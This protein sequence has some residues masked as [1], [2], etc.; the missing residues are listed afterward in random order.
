MICNAANA[1][2]E[3]FEH[4]QATLSDDKLE[5]L[6]NL[7]TCAES[8]AGNLAKTLEALALFFA[9]SDKSSLPDK[10]TVASILWGLANQ[11]L[12]ISAMVSV[13]QEAEFLAEKRKAERTKTDNNP[14]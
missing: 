6:D 12:T 11:A 1:L 2:R 10:E 3:L 4:S 8:D 5:W 14:A 13:G 7:S 9:N